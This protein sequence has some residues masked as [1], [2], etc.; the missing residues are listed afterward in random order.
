[1]SG[2]L[3]YQGPREIR[4]LFIDGG[5][6][7]GRLDNISEKYF[8][9]KTFN[10]DFANFV[11]QERFTKVFYY[12]AL[13][14]REPNE[15]EQAYEA[16]V[17]PQRE[18]FDSAA[19]VDRVHVC[20]GDARRRRKRGLVQKKVDVMIAVDM[21][22]HT[23]RRNMHEAT[24]LTGDNDFKPLVDALVHEGMFITI[25]YP[26]GETSR[27]L[28]DAAD[29]RRPLT[30]QGLRAL[31]TPDSQR[32]FAI[33][34]LDNMTSKQ[35]PGS[36][37]KNWTEGKEKHALYLDGSDYVVVTRDDPLNQLHVRHSDL[38]LLREFCKECFK[39]N[40]P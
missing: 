20:E 32:D 30:F 35:Q 23:F 16:R 34:V 39:I 27:E 6:L 37:V 8:G 33:P 18:L 25:W 28:M 21:L 29:A 31:L 13:P 40:I 9:G 19:G 11:A 15:T 17:R 22:T 2:G 10:I 14:V 4:Y 12:D 26:P 24:L 1:M 38:N 5:S 7:R 36:I 3:G